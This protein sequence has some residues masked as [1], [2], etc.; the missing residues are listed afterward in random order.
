MTHQMTMSAS[1]AY[2]TNILPEVARRNSYELIDSPS[3]RN[4]YS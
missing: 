2:T 4:R 1:T 3:M